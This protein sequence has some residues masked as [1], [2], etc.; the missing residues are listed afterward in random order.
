MIKKEID[1]NI[2]KLTGISNQYAKKKKKKRNCSFQNC[3]SS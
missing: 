3:L 1:K 2:Y